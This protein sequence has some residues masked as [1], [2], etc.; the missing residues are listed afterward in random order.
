MVK[1]FETLGKQLPKTGKHF[2]NFYLNNTF[3]TELK[4]NTFSDITFDRIDI[5]NCKNLGNI[6]E[7]AFTTTQLKTYFIGFE[8]NPSL[9]SPN[10]SIFRA[11]SKFT[12]ALAI[13]FL[14]NNISEIPSNAFGDQ[15]KLRELVFTGESIKMIGNN[16]FSGLKNLNILHIDLTSIDLFPENAFEF[17]EESNQ[18]LYLYI[19]GNKVLNSSGFSKSSL[20]KLKRPCEINLDTLYPLDHTLFS[21]LDQKVFEPFLILNTNNK[22]ILHERNLDCSD[23]RNYWLKKNPNLLK[24][25]FYYKCSNGKMLEDLVNFKNCSN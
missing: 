22:I 21:Y 25:V 13:E 15:D 2:Y 23:C 24:Q 16:A 1:I 19:Y 18:T 8:N 17:N 3:I 5:E 12:N 20:T 10:H 11:L 7:K 9:T 4:E 14:K 6:S